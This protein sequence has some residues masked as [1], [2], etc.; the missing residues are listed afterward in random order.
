MHLDG[1][2]HCGAVR[3][4]LESAHPYPYNLCYCSICRKTGGAGGY[5]INL[6][7]RCG[8]AQGGRRSPCAH[9]SGHDRRGCRAPAKPG[10]AAFLRRVRR[11]PVG[12]GPALAR[13]G[14]SA[15]LGHRHAPAGAAGAHA[16]HARLESRLGA[17][18]CRRTG[19]ALRSIPGRVHRPV[20]CAAGAGVLTPDRVRSEQVQ[21]FIHA[22]QC[23]ADRFQGGLACRHFGLA[24]VFDRHLGEAD[25]AVVVELLD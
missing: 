24:Q 2:C 16:S 15:R 25:H 4:S 14:P 13:A 6:G 19:Q 17:G 22:V 10:E 8:H 20:A 1:S 11:S 23:V 3:F 7:G 9:L 21:H 5:A 18:A 12:V